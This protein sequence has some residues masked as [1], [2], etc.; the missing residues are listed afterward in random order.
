MKPLT[1]NGSIYINDVIGLKLTDKPIK[2]F[3]G[4]VSLAT[5]RELAS[6]MHSHY[7]GYFEKICK[8]SIH[9]GCTVTTV[10]QN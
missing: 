3:T 10:H 7:T 9:N 4:Y 5:R 8:H 2:T 6:A 1:I